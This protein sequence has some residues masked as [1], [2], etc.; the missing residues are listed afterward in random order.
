M[1]RA[2]FQEISG[3]SV[4]SA[5]SGRGKTGIVFECAAETVNIRIPAFLSDRAD[6]QIGP[7]EQFIGVIKP[8]V[9]KVF[10]ERDAVGHAADFQPELRFGKIHHFRKSFDAR[11]M[12]EIFP[13]V[14]HHFIHERIALGNRGQGR[15]GLTQFP[16]QE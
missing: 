13:D 12:I 16:A 1:R 2:C 3:G 10:P 5:E 15:F 9:M 4:F 8:Q 6:R 14:L 7:F 11:R